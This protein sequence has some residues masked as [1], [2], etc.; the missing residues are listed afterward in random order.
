MSQIFHR[1][2]NVIARVSLFGAVFFIAALG[3]VFAK[4]DRSAYNTG[5]G[6][7]LAQ[8]VPFSHDHHTAALGIDCRYC[9]TNVETSAFAGLPPTA[10]CMNCHKLIWND[11]PMLEPVRESFASGVPIRWARVNDLPDYVY[12]NHS[13]H[14]AKGVGCVSCHGRVDKMPLLYQAESMQMEW[15]LDCHREPEKY[16]RPKEALFDMAWQP[17]PGTDRL[18]LG[19]ELV[20]EYRAEPSTSCSRCHR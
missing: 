19:A 4:L 7:T 12:F 10:T 16:L 15:C 3:W 8:P 2:T 1:S 17:T 18:L 9:H 20:A 13:I 11:S 5:Q 6:V 14:L